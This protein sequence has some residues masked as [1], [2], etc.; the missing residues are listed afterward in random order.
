MQE[1]CLMAAGAWAEV[2]LE[3]ISLIFLP[4]PGGL[5]CAL[6]HSTHRFPAFFVSGNGLGWGLVPPVPRHSRQA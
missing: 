1:E 5:L 3:G 6:L 2:V 4:L